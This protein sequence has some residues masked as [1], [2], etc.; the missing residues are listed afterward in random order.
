MN[1]NI[2]DTEN[3]NF[4]KTDIEN[5]KNQSLNIKSEGSG[6]DTIDENSRRIRNSKNG[7]NCEI[8]TIDSISK[9]GTVPTINKAPVQ[10]VRKCNLPIFIPHLGCPHSCAFCNQKKIT[11]KSTQITPQIAGN[12]IKEYLSTVPNGAHTEVAFFGGSFTALPLSLQEEFLKAASKFSSNLCGIRLSTR[13]DCINDEV[14]D[15]LQKYNVTEIELGA[16]SSSDEVLSVSM[17]GHTFSDTVRASKLIKS[18]GIRLGLQ[19]MLGLPKS[20]PETDIKTAKDLILLKPDSTRIY[21]T[22]VLEGTALCKMDYKP[23]TVMEAAQVAAKIIPLFNEANV[24]ILR[25]GLHSSEDLSGGSVIKGPYHPAFGEIAE[26]L[27]MRNKIEEKILCGNF[28]GS[29]PCKASE[30][31]K[32]IGH[33]KMNK[34]YFKE[35][36]NIDLK[37]AVIAK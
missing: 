23:Y 30:V 25:I 26:S 9:N 11:G 13:P 5:T 6:N 3:T 28:S 17:R 29:F 15:L 32:V 20:N 2:N 14:L 16:Q 10:N 1:L 19:M 21:P 34:I 33:K 22:V 7:G 31:S 4:K 27:I 24:T 37:A 12:M 8:C 35:K 18:R 36:Y